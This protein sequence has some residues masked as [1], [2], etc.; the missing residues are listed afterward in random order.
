MSNANS[1]DLKI[2][3]ELEQDIG[4]KLAKITLLKSNSTGYEQNEQGQVIGLSL[5]ECKLTQFPDSIV[6]LQNLAELDLRYNKLSSLPDSI[7]K[8]T[9]LTSLDLGNNKLRSVPNSIGKL[10]KLTELKLEN[11][12]LSN[13]PDSIAELQNLT[14]LN[15]GS[16]QLSSVPNS[17]IKLQ[18]LTVLYL[19]ANQLSKIPD[20]IAELQNLT[21][22]YLHGNQLSNMPDSIAKMQKLKMLYL[23]KNQLSILPDNIT[24]LKNL[25]L[26]NLANN[27]L[28]SVPD[29][30]A[31]LQNLQSLGLYDNQFTEFPQVLLMLNLEVKWE[32]GLFTYGIH[33][34]GNPFRNPPIEIVKQG[35][36]AIVKYYAPLETEQ[37]LPSP[38][39]LAVNDYKDHMSDIES[40]L[41]AIKNKIADLKEKL[42][43]QL[44]SI[45]EKFP[46]II[47]F[48][49]NDNSPGDLIQGH[50]NNLKRASDLEMPLAEIQE[51]ITEAKEALEAYSSIELSSI[52]KNTII[53]SLKKQ[54]INFE[55][56]V[57]SNNDVK[58][59]PKADFAFFV[60]LHF[61]STEELDNVI[62]KI[63]NA[64]QAMYLISNDSYFN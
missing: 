51:I 11:N 32:T 31:K 41:S 13:V 59:Y 50:I 58:I 52:I 12:Q 21:A 54:C 30:I 38:Q 43:T 39:N 1:V 7:T 4:K 15:L 26:L 62:Y 46:K 29:S 18:N 19:F 27:Q 40:A 42:E 25:R 14:E 22:L 8:L 60:G 10:K 24:E 35:K 6:K 23:H 47:S 9:N 37:E 49:G 34:A 53:L 61:S 55:D 45:R 2:I 5:Y 57:A 48:D 64:L 17:I 63:S 3:Q 44:E 56:V 36:Q 28:T 33:I 20:S 16:N